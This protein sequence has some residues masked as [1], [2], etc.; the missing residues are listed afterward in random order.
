MKTRAA[1]SSSAISDS[2][3]FFFG[4]HS[5]FYCLYALF[6]CTFRFNYEWLV[7]VPFFGNVVVCTSKRA[8][9]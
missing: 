8:L 4:V 7:F 2:D 9:Q 5:H 1:A 6:V 3:I